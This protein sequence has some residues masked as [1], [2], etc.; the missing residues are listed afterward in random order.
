MFGSPDAVKNF[1]QLHLAR[2]PYEV[3]AVLFLD[4]QNRLIS[5]EEMFRGTLTQT[6]VYHGRLSRE[7][8]SSTQQLS[9]SRTITRA[10]RCSLPGLTK[11]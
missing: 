5:M 6:S 7:A 10:V 9:Y 8:S 11:R 1:L 4:A 3:F 2:Q